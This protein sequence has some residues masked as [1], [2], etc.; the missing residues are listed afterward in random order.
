MTRNAAQS[1]RLQFS[2]MHTAIS[3]SI[4]I[5]SNSKSAITIMQNAYTQSQLSS[6]PQGRVDT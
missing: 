6:I 3:V 2:Y 4:F 1:N 5:F